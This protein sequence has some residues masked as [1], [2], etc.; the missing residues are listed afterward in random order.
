GPA[1]NVA[2]G[3]VRMAAA[4]KDERR[5]D[6]DFDHA[7]ELHELLEA[8]QHSSDTGSAVTLHDPNRVHRLP[9]VHTNPPGQPGNHA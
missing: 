6:P 1:R 3:Y 9:H 5:F 4:I 8:L 7:R 2:A